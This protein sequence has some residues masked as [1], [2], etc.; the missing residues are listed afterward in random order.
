MNGSTITYPL[1]GSD[2]DI[3]ELSP[4][5]AGLTSFIQNNFFLVP[6]L[7]FFFFKAASLLSRE[8]N[9]PFHNFIFVQLVLK[10]FQ[11]YSTTFI[12]APIV[13]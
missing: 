11:V 6:F 12:Y 5:C 9:I 8:A 2:R 7:P 1:N 13:N 10:Q 3:T 4:T